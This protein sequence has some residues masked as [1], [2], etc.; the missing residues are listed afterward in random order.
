MSNLAAT[1]TESGVTLSWDIAAAARR[2]LIYR[3]GVL[4]GGVEGSVTAFTDDASGTGLPDAT[5]FT[6]RVVA[7]G[8]TGLAAT[9]AELM[10]STQIDAV[11]PRLLEARTLDLAT[12]QL[13]LSEPIDA[14]AAVFTLVTDDAAATPVAIN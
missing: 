10:A 4:V 1:S 3:D 5:A 14:S 11:P 8:P 7:E 9:P 12:V 13:T 2:T 6:Y